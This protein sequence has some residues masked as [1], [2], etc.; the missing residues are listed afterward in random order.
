MSKSLNDDLEEGE[1]C[2]DDEGFNIKQSNAVIHSDLTINERTDLSRKC[3][4]SLYRAKS[5]SLNSNDLE[6]PH[7]SAVLSEI[8]DDNLRDK[9]ENRYDKVDET[10]DKECFF[11]H[12]VMDENESDVELRVSNFQ[13]ELVECQ[14]NLDDESE[15]DNSGFSDEIV[16]S[17]GIIAASEFQSKMAALTMD[18]ERITDRNTIADENEVQQDLM[19]EVPVDDGWIFQSLGGDSETVNV[20]RDDK[21]MLHEG[22]NIQTKQIVELEKKFAEEKENYVRNMYSLLVTARTQIA[23]LKKE[24]KKLEMKLEANCTVSCPACKHQVCLRS[25]SLKPKYI[26]VLKG[27]CAIEMLFDNVEK[28]E[29]WLAANYLDINSDGLPVVLELPRKQTLA[30]TNSL[31]VHKTNL[32]RDIRENSNEVIPTSSTHPAKRRQN[33]KSSANDNDFNKYPIRRYENLNHVVRDE[34][35]HEKTKM[36]TACGFRRKHEKRSHDRERSGSDK[37]EEQQHHGILSTYILSDGSVDQIDLNPEVLLQ[38]AIEDQLDRR[39]VVTEELKKVLIKIVKIV[40]DEI[41]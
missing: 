18:A 12:D 25:N 19:E 37:C 11:D 15:D 14:S 28:M 27:R 23:S 4:Q 38:N 1:I 26:K 20:A 22:S 41:E 29:E 5:E 7:Q 39:C 40:Q 33:K 32:I 17:E 31:L 3:L 16:C 36:S 9:S 21:Q 30:S 10:A 2:D 35:E 6:I 8:N 24:N 13:D 34:K